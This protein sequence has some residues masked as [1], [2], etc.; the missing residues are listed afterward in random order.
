MNA[1]DDGPACRASS[2]TVG[3]LLMVVVVAVLSSGALVGAFALGASPPPVAPQTAVEFG[4][5][6]GG[7]ADVLVVEHGYGETVPAARLRVEIRG[8]APAS[9][10]GRYRWDGPSLGGD[11]TV[12]AGSRVRLDPTTVGDGA[13]LDL[14]AAT[15]TVVW[16]AD[17]GEWSVALDRWEGRDHPSSV[18]GAADPGHAYV[19][20]DRDGAWDPSVDTALEDEAVTDGHYDAGDDPLVIPASVGPIA[21]AEI[22]FAGTGLTVG[23]DLTTT[24]GGGAT[25]D[26]RT[27]RLAVEGIAVD[28]TNAASR[29]RLDGDA[30]VRANGS[31]LAAAGRIEVDS[32][33]GEVALAGATVDTSAVDDRDIELESNGDLVLESAVVRTAEG[34]AVSVDV[35]TASAT[36]WVDGLTLETD[37]VSFS[38][39]GASIEGTPSSVTTP[40]G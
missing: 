1:S 7:T 24:G 26:A 29:I 37:S 21:A 13:T 16:R 18:A 23:V 39:L 30:G 10:N 34:G 15:V 19:D 9:A 3:T 35:G 4:F 38:P 40:T 25:L 2:S 17:N 32:N 11:A 27:G 14:D 22:D 33:G 6:N 31:T 5:E 8:A 36:I 20:V 12:S 28:A